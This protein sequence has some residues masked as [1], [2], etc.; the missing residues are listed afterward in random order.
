MF[1]ICVWAHILQL[2]IWRPRGGCEQMKCCNNITGRLTGIALPSLNVAAE[3]NCVTSVAKCWHCFAP[4][5]AA[6]AEVC[7]YSCVCFWLFF[8]FYIGSCSS[9]AVT[10]L[11]AFKST[12]LIRQ[13]HFEIRW[14]LRGANCLI[15]VIR[16][17]K[18]ME[19]T[20]RAWTCWSSFRWWLINLLVLN[21]LSGF[22]S[23]FFFLF[24]LFFWMW[25]Q[26]GSNHFPIVSFS[27]PYLWICLP[28]LSLLLPSLFFRFVL[29]R[30]PE[31]FS[32]PSPSTLSCKCLSTVEAFRK[33]KPR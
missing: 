5:A 18:N 7:R 17:C 22:S 8:E 20:Q 6:A 27:L 32:F 21:I 26:T 15:E 3:S 14:D 13:S 16:K 10:L 11:Q 28:F 33:K 12:M 9:A 2:V 29:P 30:M 4:K 1:P 25:S 19:N 24:L 23:C 31:D